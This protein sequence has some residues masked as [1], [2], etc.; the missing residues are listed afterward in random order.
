MLSTRTWNKT[1]KSEIEIWHLEGLLIARFV[2]LVN[3]LSVEVIQLASR[4]EEIAP[5][6]SAT[7]P[8][9]IR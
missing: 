8:L 9:P 7:L 1:P 6:L 3:A 2:V 4:F 5:A